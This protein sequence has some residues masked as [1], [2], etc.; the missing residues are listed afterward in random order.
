[1]H[2]PRNTPPLISYLSV[3]MHAFFT[4]SL[5]LIFTSAQQAVI[6][7][8]NA[9]AAATAPYNF[10]L[11]GRDWPGLCST[12]RSQSPI[13]IITAETLTVS[14]PD[15]S[16]LNIDIPPHVMPELDFQIY[17]MWLGNGT[18]SATFNGQEQQFRLLDVHAHTPAAHLIDG[19]R[20]A[21]EVHFNL[22]P[23]FDTDI[24]EFTLGLMFR[25]GPRSAF[26]DG[27]VNGTDADFS[28]LSSGP[29]ENYFYYSGSRDVPTPDCVEPT[30]FVI[31]DEVFTVSVDQLQALENGPNARGFQ[32]SNGHGLYREV[33][34]LNGRT[35]Y[36]RTTAQ[37]SSS[38]LS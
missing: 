9:A 1:M 25:D 18:L 7:G 28:T 11:G 31:L 20:Y 5:L 6:D 22:V 13:D 3:I 12:G 19:L 35:V 21:M 29:I 24:Q 8:I 34:P 36:H 14:D 30:I 32:A 16:A 10:T 37:D 33:Q 17:A 23:L 4:T 26:I 27:I 2:I 38:F 15:F